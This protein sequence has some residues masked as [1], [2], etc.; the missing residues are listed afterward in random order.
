MYR[1]S[2]KSNQHFYNFI[3]LLIT[4]SLFVAGKFGLSDLLGL[5]HLFEGI[6]FIP[7]GLLGFFIIAGN[8]RVWKDQ[9]FLLPFFYLVFQFYWHSTDVLTIGDL[10]I[11]VLVVGMLSNM[12]EDFSEIILGC[13]ILTATFFA[14][15]GIIEFVLVFMDPTLI[16]ETIGWTDGSEPVLTYAIQLLGFSDGTFYHIFGTPITRLMSFVTEPSLLLIYFLIPGALALTY[17]NKYKWC[18]FVCIFFSICSLSG[19]ILISIFFAVLSYLLVRLKSARAFAWVPFAALIV[20]GLVLFHYYSD[21][22]DMAG[23]LGYQGDFLGKANSAN[24]R[25]SYIKDHIFLILVAPFGID[26]TINGCLGF[27]LAAGAQCGVIG[28]I[29]AISILVKIY[30]KTGYILIQKESNAIMK[31]GLLII[32]GSLISIM[33]Y[34]DYGFNKLFGFTL[35]F[36]INNRLSVL[37]NQFQ[38]ELKTS[39]KVD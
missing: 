4:L 24:Q 36:L 15:L 33:L 11:T 7:L 25:F 3:A 22:I 27:V 5:K 18:G 26:E 23:N 10:S 29:L 28:I 21:L 8:N 6:F 34:T 1:F 32:Y 16:P 2:M 14:T 37:T 38:K 17:K 12:E 19:S 35:L 20:F 13:T 39:S 31:T 30:Y 9:L